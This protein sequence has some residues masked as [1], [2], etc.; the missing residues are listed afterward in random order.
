MGM[1]M[2]KG[3]SKQMKPENPD[4]DEPSERT[5]RTRW[6]V[7]L[8]FFFFF[9]CFVQ[10]K[11]SKEERGKKKGGELLLPLIKSKMKQCRKGK[12]KKGSIINIK[13][14]FFLLFWEGGY[15]YCYY[16]HY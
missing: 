15:S 9:F 16:Y 4:E 14:P 7:G 1:G 10:K 8:F 2:E 12:V 3:S 6:V 5:A 11:R 13:N